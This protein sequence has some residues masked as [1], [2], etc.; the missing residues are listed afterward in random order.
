MLS[1]N[2]LKNLR[3]RK[4]LTQ[5]ELSH[6]LG[7]ED[8]YSYKRIG[9]YEREE[10]HPKDRVMARLAEVLDVDITA[11]MIPNGIDATVLMQLLFAMEDEF[12]MDIQAEEGCVHLS[13]ANPRDNYRRCAQY[14][15][16]WA[17]WHKMYTTGQ[18]TK[19]EYDTLRYNFPQSL[20]G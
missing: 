3:K 6:K 18:I 9:Q 1:G 20:L 10:R 8:M 11:L 4:K 19:E 14:L 15:Q 2:R 5:G 16:I 17:T 13:L 7:F 12:D